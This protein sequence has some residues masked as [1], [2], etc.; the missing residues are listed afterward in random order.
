MPYVTPIDWRP[1]AVNVVGA[2]AQDIPEGVVE[3]APITGQ[4]EHPPG[5]GSE[6]VAVAVQVF[7]A[8]TV[9]KYVPTDRPVWF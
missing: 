9:T 4:I 5:P 2:L 1:T 7:A 6:I 8:V 3:T